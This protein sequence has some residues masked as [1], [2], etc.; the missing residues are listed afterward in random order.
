[1]AS[2][3]LHKE[4]LERSRK[5]RDEEDRLMGSKPRREADEGVMQHSD[6]TAAR[7]WSEP[8]DLSN[9]VPFLEDKIFVLSFASFKL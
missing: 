2:I 3:W 9:I 8:S 4:R 6:P 5:K 7:D 1:M